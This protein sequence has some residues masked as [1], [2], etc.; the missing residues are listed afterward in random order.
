M[1]QGSSCSSISGCARPQRRYP[2]D[3]LACH[4]L[5]TVG[6]VT[7]L[8]IEQKED[9]GYKAGDFAGR[10]GAEKEYEGRLRGKDGRRQTQVDA[11]GRKVGLFG[12]LE[13]IPASP[14]HDLQLTLDM[15]LQGF[16]EDTLSSYSRGAVVVVDVPSGGV[17]AMASTPAFD[18]NSFS[19]RS[20]AF[21]S[22]TTFSFSFKFP[23]KVLKLYTLLL[24]HKK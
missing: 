16:V 11:L 15:G 20:I 5:G 19:R 22:S 3:G 10:R 17:L 8:E 6:E 13:R 14:G 21:L 23:A 9:N 18:P 12:G 7:E 1:D 2:G 24:L 4:L